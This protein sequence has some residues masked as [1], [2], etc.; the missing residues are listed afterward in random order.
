M[1]NTNVVVPA[2]ARCSVRVAAA[3]SGVPGA[4]DS[5]CTVL[6]TDIP[7]I[8]GA[9]AGVSNANGAGEAGIPLIT[10]N[11]FAIGRLSC[12]ALT[13]RCKPQA[14]HYCQAQAFSFFVNHSSGSPVNFY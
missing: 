10:H 9:G 1:P 3:K 14:Q 8:D 2:Q 13:G 12:C 5:V 4:G 6:P 11:I 7:S